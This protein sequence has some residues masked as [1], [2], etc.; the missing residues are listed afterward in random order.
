MRTVTETTLR[1][2]AMLGSIPVVP[3]SKSTRQ[4][5]EELRDKDP[6]Y[7]VSMRSIQRSLE[8]L[9]GL[10]P[11]TSM[12]R[13][14]ANYWCWTEKNALTQIPAMSESTAFVLRLAAEHLKPIMPPATLRALDPYFQHADKILR[15]TAL[16]RWTDKA[17]II[18]QGLTL[19]PPTVPA[20][21][22]EVVYT[23]LMNYQQIQVS[24]RGKGGTRT[25]RIVLNPLAIV[26]RS[27][28][29]YLVATSWGYK[30]IR[31]YVLHRMSKPRLL[32][33]PAKAPPGFCLAAHIRTNSQFSYPLSPEKL[34]LRALFDSGA[35][36]HLT[37]SRLAADHRV[38]ER[39]DG[40]ILIEATVP[41]TA[42]LRWWLAGFGSAVEVLE[43]A[44]LRAEFREHAR[45]LRVMYG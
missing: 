6:D 8:R 18:P 39:K 5:R 13:G 31:H 9:S 14:R 15:K 41:D 32:D 29:V 30:D 38:N 36:A 24:Y 44:S 7:D 1:Y 12:T 37:E 16:G 21:V 10:F 45:R 17:A 4:I 23:A 25:Q 40:R 33:E 11:I 27:G 20:D 42:D 22:Q 28:I 3:H 2:L 19:E 34:Q 35:G 26:V 43:P